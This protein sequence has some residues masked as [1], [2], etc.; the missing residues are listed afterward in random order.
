MRCQNAKELL[1][2]IR[3]PLFSSQLTSTSCLITIVEAED[4]D[5]IMKL[6][7]LVNGLTVAKKHVLLITSTFVQKKIVNLT[8]H[9]QVMVHHKESGMKV[10]KFWISIVKFVC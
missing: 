9:F 4:R 7:D 2:L 8:I 6:L 10:M 3:N 1:K 5:E